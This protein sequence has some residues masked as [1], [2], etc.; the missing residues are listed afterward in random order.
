MVLGDMIYDLTFINNLTS[1]LKNN[2]EIAP[3]SSITEIIQLIYKQVGNPNYV[4][5]PVFT[6]SE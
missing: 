6:K 5:T 2:N 1:Q 4:K 3:E